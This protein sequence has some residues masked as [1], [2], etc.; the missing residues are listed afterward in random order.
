MIDP[1]YNSTKPAGQ[2]EASPA[3]NAGS[4][5]NPPEVSTLLQKLMIIILNLNLKDDTLA[6]IH[7]LVAAGATP[8]QIILVDNGSTD[9]CVAEIRKR[10]NNQINLI[11]NEQN[12]GFATGNNQGARLALHL[13][14]EWLLLL[15]NDTE[16]APDFFLEIEQA[17]KSDSPY[18]IFSPAIYYYSEPEIIW[19]LGAKRF[20]GTLLARNLY[21]GQKRPENLPDLMPTDFISGCGMLLHRSVF[22]RVGL[23]DD[24]F[25]I[26]WEEVDFSM[27]ASKA[28]YK[29]A[30]ITRAKMWHKVSRTMSRVK[31]RT[32]YL[33]TRNLIF[34]ARKNASGLQK[35][36]MLFILIARLVI[37]IF[38]DIT[39]GQTNLIKPLLK[40]WVDGWLE[41]GLIR[42]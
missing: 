13:G 17:I 14:A 33:Y 31:D 27:R 39:S 24:R 37:T 22:E 1:D 16:V 23:F 28:G 11:E 8:D 10:F 36:S 34:Y 2:L 38:R 40:G 9:G 32:R 41:K 3:Q 15:N 21:Q 30:N 6:L 4:Q 19:H 20:P 5:Y 42:T 25:I 12:L 35:L 29:M 26:Y 18:L 7:S